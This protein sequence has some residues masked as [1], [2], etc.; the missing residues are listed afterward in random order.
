MFYISLFY[1]H[2]LTF[3]SLLYVYLILD[4]TILETPASFANSVILGSGFSQ[5]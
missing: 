1:L 4:I 2:T 3:S 5:S